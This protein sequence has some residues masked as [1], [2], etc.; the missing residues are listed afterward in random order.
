MHIR[1]SAS[2]SEHARGE[3][4]AIED[5]Q[6]VIDNDASYDAYV[7]AYG[8]S[9]LAGSSAPP[10]PGHQLFSD[11]DSEDDSFDDNSDNT[12]N[13]SANLEQLIVRDVVQDVH[14]LANEVRNINVANNNFRN[15][16]AAKDHGDVHFDYRSATNLDGTF[17][18]N[19]VAVVKH[20]RQR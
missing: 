6:V 18:K 5:H 4:A 19:I 10:A 9:E 2:R 8:T 3:Q 16:A 20:S 1:Y 13:A 11:D 12:S 17:S 15:A 14:L 7:P